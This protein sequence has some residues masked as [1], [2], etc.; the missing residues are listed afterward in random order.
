[1]L[2]KSQGGFGHTEDRIAVIFVPQSHLLTGRIEGK[3]TI[4]SIHVPGGPLD[5]QKVLKIVFGIRAFFL[6][7]TQFEHFLRLPSC[8]W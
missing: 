7:K 3:T 1:M 4:A 2:K 8:F 5:A 6:L